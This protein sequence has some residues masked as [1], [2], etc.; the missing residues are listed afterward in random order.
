MQIAQANYQV[1]EV[2]VATH[3]HSWQAA[4]LGKNVSPY[5]KSLVKTKVIHMWHQWGWLYEERVLLA[6][7]I[8]SE[9]EVVKEQL[10]DTV[11]KE[12]STVTNIHTNADH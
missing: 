8:R 12:P 3:S 5:H 1:L 11:S 7:A 9:R 10:K 2:A 6:V 4:R